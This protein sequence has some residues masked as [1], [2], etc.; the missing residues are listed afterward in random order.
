MADRAFRFAA[1]GERDDSVSDREFGGGRDFLAGV[2]ADPERGRG[3]GGED[4]GELVQEVAEG[5]RVSA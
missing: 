4:A 2:F 3:Q 5:S 1:C